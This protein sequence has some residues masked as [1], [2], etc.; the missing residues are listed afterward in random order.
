MELKKLQ[1]LWN[2]FPDMSLEERPVLSSDL[3]HIV[4]KKNGLSVL[5]DE[6]NVGEVI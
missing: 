5:C 3:E 1:Q 4:V 6:R 2:S